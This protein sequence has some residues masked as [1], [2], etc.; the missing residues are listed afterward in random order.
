MKN[1]LSL[2]GY[3]GAGDN[4]RRKSG[5][6]Y[7]NGAIASGTVQYNLFTNTSL[8]TYD[9]NRVFPLSG[10]EIFEIN[11]VSVYFDFYQATKYSNN[12]SVF[13]QESFVQIFVDEREKLK[14]PL[15]EVASFFFGSSIGQG[16][17][18]AEAQTLHTNF[19][20][21]QRNLQHAI[22]I[23]ANSNVKIVLVTTSAMSAAF[24]LSTFKVT[25]SGIKYDK[26][27]DFEVDFVKNNNLE[28][29]S[30]SLYDVVSLT[31]AEETVECFSVRNKAETLF[32]KVLPL[33]D[34][35]NFQIEAIEIFGR[36]DKTNQQLAA[37]DINHVLDE[38]MDYSLEINVDD[39]NLFQGNDPQMFG[40][41]FYKNAEIDNTGGVDTT[42]VNL[43][44]IMSNTYVL[45]VPIVIP[46]N[47]K[48]SIKLRHR[49]LTVPGGNVLISLKGTLIRKIA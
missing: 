44:K 12:L 14:L 41:G 43:L 47:S 6:L 22:I 21:R 26:L 34:K 40:C 5:A 24:N 46:A 28:R 13:L 39:V 8:S 35:E 29:L 49:A 48:A 37:Y 33:S 31:S 4:A 27:T 9:R 32:N 30:Y 16:T 23:N 36:T 15:L 7:D 25:L 11:S 17:A 10:S 1:S 20:K 19:H 38:M 3:P 45:P 2:F 42:K 18:Y